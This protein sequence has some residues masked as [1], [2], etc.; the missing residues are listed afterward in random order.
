[1]KPSSNQSVTGDRKSSKLNNNQDDLNS[2]V[3]E[4]TSSPSIIPA[5]SITPSSVPTSSTRSSITNPTNHRVETSKNVRSNRTPKVTNSAKQQIASRCDN[6][7]KEAK[8][9]IQKEAVPKSKTSGKYE[10]KGKIPCKQN[11]PKQNEKNIQEKN[12][13]QDH[14]NRKEPIRMHRSADRKDYK[15]YHEY[16][17][18]TFVKTPP[19]QHKI[20]RSD[21]V[22][23]V[24]S[25]REMEEKLALNKALESM[26][27]PLHNFDCSE[28]SIKSHE[29][30]SY[31]YGKLEVN[32]S[33]ATSSIKTKRNEERNVEKPAQRHM[34]RNVYNTEVNLVSCKS[35]NARS[36]TTDGRTRKAH[37]LAV[38]DSDHKE[39]RSLT[40]SPQLKE[41]DHD[42]ILEKYKNFEN[43]QSLVDIKDVE[44]QEEALSSG[45]VMKEATGYQAVDF[46][47]SSLPAS[48]SDP[49][50]C[51][52]NR[53]YKDDLVRSLTAT[54]LSI[55]GPENRVDVNY[56][57]SRQWFSSDKTGQL[58][59]SVRSVLSDSQSSESVLKEN[60]DT[61]VKKML[62]EVEI[63]GKEYVHPDDVR[64]T[65]TYVERLFCPAEKK[66]VRLR[67]TRARV[68]A[69]KEYCLFTL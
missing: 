44:K 25:T 54:P 40:S 13:L 68:R 16:E 3:P 32:P 10:D 59:H 2:S 28:F 1:M 66:K 57:S 26:C 46:S 42:D 43:T 5:R 15:A 67:D 69:K 51:D 35:R 47:S 37:K 18:R 52:R 8:S 14:D 58:S 21:T 41:H 4:Y 27:N 63:A 34:E 62:D 64:C 65:D 45:H 11:V 22:E 19:N 36:N 49:E 39:G 55:T 61:N 56:F 7:E 60:D 53:K 50:S 33:A 48:F 38:T 24:G 23:E 6:K 20:K 29:G 12:M 9:T 31:G 30:M 17:K